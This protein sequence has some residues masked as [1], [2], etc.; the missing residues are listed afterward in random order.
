[1]PGT[2]VRDALAANL[3]TGAT[4]NA[5]GTTNGTAVEIAKPGSCRVFLVTSTVTGTSP[6]LDVTIQ[7]ADDSGFTTNVVTEGRFAL[8]TGG[9]QSNVTRVLDTVIDKRYIRAV[10]LIAGTSPV[11]TGTTI[12][13]RERHD[14]KNQ[15]SDTA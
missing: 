5:A 13:V 8:L 15:V 6:T 7:G 4:L 10:V 11:Y 9:S 3:A 1:M 14:R 2:L 12:T